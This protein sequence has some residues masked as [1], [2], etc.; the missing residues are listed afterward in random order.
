MHTVRGWDSPVKRTGCPFRGPRW[1]GS[2]LLPASSQQSLTPVPGNRSAILASMSTVCMRYTYTH[3]HKTAM[4]IKQKSQ[5][6]GITR[7]TTKEQN[8]E[9]LGQLISWSL[10]IR[11]TVACMG[12][13]SA[14]LWAPQLLG[15]VFR[16]IVFLLWVAGT[17]RYSPH[18]AFHPVDCTLSI[19]GE[20]SGHS[21]LVANVLVGNIPQVQRTWPQH[22][23]WSRQ[24]PM[25]VLSTPPECE[26]S[27][28]RNVAQG[29]M[30]TLFWNF[31]VCRLDSCDRQWL[32][33]FINSLPQVQHHQT[34]HLCSADELCHQ[35]QAFSPQAPP[36]LSQVPCCLGCLVC[37]NLFSYFL[38]LLLLQAFMTQGQWQAKLRDSLTCGCSL[39]SG[40]HCS[41]VFL[42]Y[43][44]MCM[45]VLS[46]CISVYPVHAQHF[47]RL[48][49]GF[50]F[51]G[52]GVTNCCEPTCRY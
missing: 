30:C 42:Y 27:C 24:R 17:S 7:V 16:E 28:W 19:S 3:A 45:C 14:K 47:K 35:R 39:V 5:N 18:P 9:E 44:F 40:P 48:K 10:K 25:S 6:G 29:I 21:P 23:D 41:L 8:E 26:S 46:V 49:E 22:E 1:L 51:P 36:S 52:T 4:H 38:E 11:V 50:G 37:H 13:M 43:N 15:A 12:W 20:S 34:S 33:N 31:R 2:L 32:Q